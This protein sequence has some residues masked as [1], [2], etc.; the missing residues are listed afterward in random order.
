MHRPLIHFLVSSPG[1][2]IQADRKKWHLPLDKDPAK[3]SYCQYF[4]AIED[5]L[6]Y[7]NFGAFLESINQK[8]KQRISIETIKAIV[9]RSEKHGTLYHPASIEVFLNTGSRK[10]GLNVATTETGMQWLK[11]EF[12]VLRLLSE[13]YRLP[14]LPYAYRFQKRNR[15]AF[16]LEDWFEGYHEFHLSQKNDGRQILQL[17]EFGSGYRDLTPEQAYEIYRQS[18]LIMTLYYDIS[19]YSQIYPWHHGGGDFIAHVDQEG[20]SV[21]LTTARGY[22]P[23]MIF[24]DTANGNPSVALAYFFL[25]LTLKMSLD[26]LD[27]VGEVTWADNRYVPATVTG[28]FDGLQLKEDYQSRGHD[29]LSVMRSFSVDEMKHIF[30]PLIKMYEGTDDH[31]V[32]VKNLDRHAEI[33]TATLQNYLR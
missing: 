30:S 9:I 16:L 13:K 10:F 2:D 26:R 5:F 15:M 7:D 22:N 29:M 12:S 18:S 14:Y 23:L 6:S 19:D 25:N 17:W 27:G 32:I 4:H 8:E 24:Q 21:R 31:A 33:L 1:G 28:F 20:I 3:I 11:E